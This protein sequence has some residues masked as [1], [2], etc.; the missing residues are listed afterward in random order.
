MESSVCKSNVIVENFPL[1]QPG[2]R[3]KALLDKLKDALKPADAKRR[4]EAAAAAASDTTHD[5]RH[6]GIEQIMQPGRRDYDEG[7]NSGGGRGLADTLKSKAGFGG[8]SGAGAGANTN[9]HEPHRDSTHIDK[10]DDQRVP[11]NTYRTIR[12]DLFK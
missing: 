6:G 2:G 7:K 3:D 8:N 10:A 4:A 1:I 11:G 9:P 12:D 5:G